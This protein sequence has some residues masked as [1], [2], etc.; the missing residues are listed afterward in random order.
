MNLSGLHEPL[1]LILKAYAEAG[2]R[3][4]SSLIFRVPEKVS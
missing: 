1:S 3:S 2:Q 4:G